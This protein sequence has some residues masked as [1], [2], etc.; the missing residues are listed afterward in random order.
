MQSKTLLSLLAVALA[1]PMSRPQITL[2]PTPIFAGQQVTIHAGPNMAIVVDLDPN[3]R[4]RLTT[5]ANGEATFTP[6]N[7]GSLFVTDP[8]GNWQAAADVVLP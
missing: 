3:G 8:A 2:S 1:L 7:G 6:P 4:W 5:D